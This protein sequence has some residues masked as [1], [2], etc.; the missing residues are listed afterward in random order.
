MKKYFLLIL[1][2]LWQFGLGWAQESPM[3]AYPFE[4][5]ELEIGDSLTLSYVETGEGEETILFL[6]GLGSYLPVWKKNLAD[7]A[8]NY[9]CIALDLP[10]H[11]LSSKDEYDY[12]MAFFARSLE[13]FL[14]EKTLDKVHLIGHSMGGQIALT[15]ALAH[16]EKVNQMV[17]LAPAGLEVFSEDQG[18]LMKTFVT[19]QSIK[20]TSA[21]KAESNL[22][23][24]FYQKKLPSDAAFML[25]DRLAM[26][27]N[28]D[29]D[30]YARAISLS[31]AGMI[32]GPVFS[33][34][35][36]VKAPVLILFG[37]DDQLIPN[38]YFNPGLSLD[39]LGEQATEALPN[40]R[41]ELI[42]EA[43][44]MLAFE[45]AEKVNALIRDFLQKK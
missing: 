31:V 38:R 42:E 3:K 29:Y 26:K 7:L 39:K 11:G 43:G 32:D 9:R 13:A 6:H 23:S 2:L 19:S 8:Q 15:F 18:N 35:N 44:H 5:K 41:F 28:P 34:L 45:Q 20:N 33:R 1:P 37:K 25:E 40:S 21:Q 24:N 36:E 16:P 12:S 4:P 27:D 17:L 22:A 14:Q 10:G 30:G